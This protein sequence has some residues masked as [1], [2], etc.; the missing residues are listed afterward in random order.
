MPVSALHSELAGLCALVCDADAPPGAISASCEQLFL[1]F[2]RESGLDMT[3]HSARSSLQIPE[4]I[5]IGPSWGA[6]CILDFMRTRAFLRGVREALNN[7]NGGHVLYAGTGPFAALLFPILPALPERDFRFTLLDIH[8]ENIGALRRLIE[9]LRFPQQRFKLVEADATSYRC[10]EP[11]D[12]LIL[13]MM[14]AGLKEEPQVAAMRNL[15]PQMRDGGLMIPESIEIAAAMR[16]TPRERERMMGAG[17]AD[18]VLHSLGRIMELRATQLPSR[19][20]PE[21]AFEL[22]ETLDPEFNELVL[23][24][25]IRILGEERLGYAESA[26]TQA[27]PLAKFRAGQNRPSKVVFQYQ[28]GEHPGFLCR[29]S[30]KT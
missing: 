20:F 24:T 6:Q 12:V 4:G 14:Q 23:T 19:D 13:E 5:A 1:F 25:G 29:F 30:Q 11:V 21:I 17:P 26:L 15:C 18:P 10:D 22:P 27:L 3:S 8:P 2:K 28:S 16:H 7:R 9:A